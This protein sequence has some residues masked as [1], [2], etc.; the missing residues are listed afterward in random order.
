MTGEGF[1]LVFAINDKNTFQEVIQLK[2]AVVNLK[3]TS[4]VPFVV[5]GNKCDMESQRQVSRQE[6]EQA[7]DKTPYIETSA[8]VLFKQLNEF[9]V[10]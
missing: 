6:V 9:R 8:K 3:D 2:E 10:I 5:V 7:F 1:L 4:K